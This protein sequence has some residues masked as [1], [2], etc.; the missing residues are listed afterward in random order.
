[1]KMNLRTSKTGAHGDLERD[2]DD[3]KVSVLVINQI[4]R[5]SDLLQVA[6]FLTET[7]DALEA[8]EKKIAHV[9]TED[10]IVPGATVYWFWKTPAFNEP[11]LVLK[12]GD[13]ALFVKLSG[14]FVAG[15]CDW[16]ARAKYAVGMY[17]KK[18]GA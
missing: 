5:A 10:D 1:M 17:Y 6:A 18:P 7:A 14:S 11:R 15:S 2:G 4:M 3:Q 16:N 13:K 9:L 8:E 12:H